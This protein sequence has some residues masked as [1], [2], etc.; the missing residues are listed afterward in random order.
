MKVS[1]ATTPVPLTRPP[2]CTR[3]RERARVWMCVWTCVW[4][5][6]H[7]C[8]CWCSLHLQRPP[9][10]LTQTMQPG[11]QTCGGFPGSE[12]YEKMDADTFASWGVDYL[13]LVCT[14]VFLSS[15]HSGSL[16]F[17]HLN[18]FRMGNL[19][20]YSTG[21]SCIRGAFFCLLLYVSSSRPSTRRVLPSRSV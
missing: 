21:A 10:Y 18:I 17:L 1:A 13:K 14:D 7:R 9:T 15:L 5:G 2:C 12:G 20:F 19:A 6:E 4:G 11:T 16:F 3:R 8:V